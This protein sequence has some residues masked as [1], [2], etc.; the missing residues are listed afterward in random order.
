MNCVTFRSG[1]QQ[2][3]STPEMLA[4]LRACGSCLEQA[5]AVDPD[6]LF[7]SLG[8]E[9]E[10]AGGVDAFVEDVMHEVH[11]RQTERALGHRPRFAS[12][13]RY[14]A[15]AAL[16]AAVLTITLTSREPVGTTVV[17]RRMPPPAAVVIPNSLPAVDS[18]EEASA[19]IVELPMTQN[20]NMKIVM[21]FDE[22]LPV[23]L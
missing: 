2:G 22:T 3:A 11:L 23:E 21:I 5:V 19:T 4:H 20:D 12:R 6:F 14:A 16:A 10:P 8:G 18:Y 1:L 7:R 13:W 17:D 15:A 9:L